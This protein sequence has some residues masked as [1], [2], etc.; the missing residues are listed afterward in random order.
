M[1]ASFVDK[2]GAAHEPPLPLAPLADTHGH[3]TH[4]RHAEPHEALAR[5][6]RS[7]V[8]LLVVPVDP[9]DEVA[10]GKRFEA[11]AAFLSWLDDVIAVARA[12]LAPEGLGID[13]RIVAGV[14]PYGA[15]EVDD[16]ALARLGELLDS[17]LSVGVGE[18]GFDFGPWAKVPLEAQEA[19]FRAQLS[20]AHERNLP[21]ELHLRD[22]DAG[23]P[24]GHDHAERVLREMGIPE[25][26]CDL[27]CFT[28]GP[29]VMA[30]F[31]EM[32]CHIAFG[33]AAT[34]ASSDAIRA[35]AAEC[36]LDRILLETDSPYMAPVP[37][38]G[39]ECEPGMAAFT[40]SVL[41]DVREAA[42]ASSRQET[43]DALWGNAR[44]LLAPE[45]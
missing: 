34:F 28:S 14:H 32:G 31:V 25:A 3:I 10:P 8:R 6:A 11:P 26:G 12:Q 43:Y 39:R 9:V 1:Q 23:E 20:V 7:G 35:A 38:R 17:P 5:A 2:K 40:A 33:G 41:A 36:P 37:L 18:F 15:E 21:I 42:G 13:V 19:A 45:R 29:E 24:I 44:A 27:H 4:F 22:P 16:A 30:P